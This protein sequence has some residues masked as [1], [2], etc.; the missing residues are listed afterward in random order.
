MEKSQ[1]LMCV[2]ARVYP[3]PSFG[4]KYRRRTS[5]RSFAGS[6][7]STHPDD[8]V[9]APPN[10]SIDWNFWPM[11]KVIVSP[12]AGPAPEDADTSESR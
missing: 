11:S 3:I 12:V 7:A 1:L 5:R 6:W 4:S 8:S 9:S 2:R 10:P